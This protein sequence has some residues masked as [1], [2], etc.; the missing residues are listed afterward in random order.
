MKDP[1]IYNGQP[2]EEKSSEMTMTED[3]V[4][5]LMEKMQHIRKV[6]AGTATES[7]R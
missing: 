7:S 6:M 2:F 4:K 3:A 5:A 1:T